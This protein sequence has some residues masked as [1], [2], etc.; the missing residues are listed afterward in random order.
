MKADD[1]EE[2]LFFFFSKGK[3]KVVFVMKRCIFYQIAPRDQ[4]YA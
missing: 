1:N 4:I 3:N 2:F